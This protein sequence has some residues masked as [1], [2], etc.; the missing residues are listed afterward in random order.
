MGNEPDRTRRRYG[1]L[2]TDVL[3]ALWSAERPLTAMQIKDALGGTL[4]YNTVY[5]VITRLA[6]KHLITRDANRRGAWRAAADPADQVAQVMT[7]ALT[8]GPDRTAVLQRFIG[9]LS[10]ADEAALRSLLAREEP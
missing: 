3:A 7:Q 10:S 2:E 4:A 8:R 5:T 9:R 6:A 1:Q